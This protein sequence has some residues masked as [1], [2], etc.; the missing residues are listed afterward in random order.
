MKHVLVLTSTFPLN[1]NDGTN[2]SV[3]NICLELARYFKITL[4]LP[5]HRDF[6]MENLNNIEVIHFRYFWPRYAQRLIYEQG[7]VP[8]IKSNPLYAFQALTF[9]ICQIIAVRKICAREKIDIILANWA[10]PSGLAGVISSK[11]TVVYIHGSDLFIKNIFYKIILKIIIHR[12]KHIITV[13]KFLEKRIR[14]NYKIKNISTVS[15]GTTVKSKAK[16]FAQNNYLIFIGRLIKGKG[17]VELISAFKIISPQYRNLKLYIIGEGPQ[18]KYFLKLAKE[19]KNIKFFGKVPSNKVQSYLSKGKVLIF[20]SKLD[21][22][23]PNIILEAGI[24]KIPIIATRS[25]GVREIINNQTGFLTSG[26]PR[27]MAQKIQDVLDNYQTAQKKSAKLFQ[28]IRNQH[29]VSASAKKITLILNS[30]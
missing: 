1:E 25:G 10:L 20:P 30:L 22:G 5:D 24:S 3:K 2:P 11:K 26:R 27:D 8:K 12:S 13:S 15:Q 28:L 9:V 17:V 6:K 23:L 29:S 21:E 4:L 16:L 18:Q 19:N 14:S 7:I